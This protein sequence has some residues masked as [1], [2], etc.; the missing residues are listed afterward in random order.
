MFRA[1][2]HLRSKATTNVVSKTLNNKSKR[3]IASATKK[4]N[5]I[6]STSKNKDVLC[7]KYNKK[8]LKFS[9]FQRFNFPSVFFKRAP[10]GTRLAMYH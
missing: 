5:N 1:S 3:S 10:S 2:Q 9:T 4:R 6:T 8:T 7:N